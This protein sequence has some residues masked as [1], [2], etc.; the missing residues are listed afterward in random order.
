MEGA[1]WLTPRVVTSQVRGY[2]VFS[3]LASDYLALLRCEPSFNSACKIEFFD[4]PDPD[5]ELDVHELGLEMTPEL[6]FTDPLE[7]VRVPQGAR[8]LDYNGTHFIVTFESGH[9]GVATGDYRPECP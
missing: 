7:M 5:G 8:G 1:P 9:D 2:C 4:A 6:N 3:Q